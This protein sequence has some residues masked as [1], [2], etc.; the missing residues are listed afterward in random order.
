MNNN[1]N[2]NWKNTTKIPFFRR[3]VL[4]NFPFI[5]KDFDALTDYEL[6]S[7]VVEY[8]NK[9]IE[10]QNITSDN[11]NELYRVYEL[12]KNYV[13]H[14]F[15]NLDVQ[16]EINN[17]LDNMVSDG[18]LTNLI[19]NY[20]DPIYQ[21]YETEINGIVN[22]QNNRITSIENQVQSVASGSPLVASSTAG[23]TNT[24]RIYVNTTDGKWYYYDGDSWE[25]GGTYQSTGISDNSITPFM[26]N[27]KTK[28][29][30]KTRIPL[31]TIVEGEYVRF[32]NTIV[33]LANTFRSEPF[34]INKGETIVLKAKGYFT[35]VGMISECSQDKS[36]INIVKR[37]IS[38]DLEEYTYTAPND[39]YIMI[40]Y[41]P[42][43]CEYYI[44]D[45]KNFDEFNN[46]NYDKTTYN[47]LLISDNLNYRQVTHTFEPINDKLFPN[48]TNIIVNTEP[49]LVNRWNWNV[50]KN[51]DVSNFNDGNN[52]ITAV[53]DIKCSSDVRL[54]LLDNSYIPIENTIIKASN[55]YQRVL[56]SSINPLDNNIV[57]V[58]IGS[59]EEKAQQN[60]I[61]L[62][63]VGLFINQE[64]SLIL[65]NPLTISDLKYIFQNKNVY[66]YSSMSIIGDSYSAYGGWIPNDGRWSWYKPEGNTGENNVSDVS[67]MWW[68][69][70]ANMINTSLLYLDGWSGST[71]CTTGQNGADVSNSA[72]V[73]RVNNSMGSARVLQPKPNLIFIFG[74]TNDSWMNS[75]VGEVK[76]SNWSTNDLKSVLPAFCKMVDTI[77]KYNPGARIINIINTDIKQSIQSGM[78][79]ACTHYG[80]ENI[81]PQNV[82]KQSGHPNQ[83]GMIT[84]AN[85][86]FNI[87]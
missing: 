73:N 30:I 57:R 51:F 22:T 21:E 75:P 3:C 50:F 14:Y 23:M 31:L 46:I 40:S 12:L 86:I 48:E 78:I 18:T 43:V 77:K 68:Y 62:R 19:K 63:L 28:E 20:V 33:E 66:K 61:S 37:S 11:T 82:S 10:Q 5:E 32:N 36:D 59:Q 29:I 15:E 49:T 71:I 25:I 1:L 45:N 79:E 85:E 83:A 39:T 52:K 34:L 72:M 24:N 17:K 80:I 2:P 16:N 87:L 27:E 70:L 4:Q 26:L 65:N 44:Y 41:L 60:E 6:L 53:I 35:N 9:V 69:I 64:E 56:L 84:I 13:E 7:K 55:E 74:G 42:G 8:L 38:S 81:I 76:Y 47:S 54:Y 58:L 67:Q